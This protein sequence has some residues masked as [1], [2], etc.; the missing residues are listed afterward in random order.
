M[1]VLD[2]SAVVELLLSTRTGHRVAERISDS[3]ERPHAPHLLA[4]EVAQTVR[5][6]AA[7]GHISHA[8]GEEAL[9]TLAQLRVT[10]WEH[11]PLLLRVWELREN[12]TAYDAV[13]VALSEVLDAPLLT[14]DARLARATGHAAR[15]DLVTG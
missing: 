11:E 10:R 3:G 1:I 5:R 7:R 12:V 2:A 8:D 15:I 6:F 13:Y 9:G 4:V 14:T